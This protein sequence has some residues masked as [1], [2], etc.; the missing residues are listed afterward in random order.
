M[1]F[2][3]VTPDYCRSAHESNRHLDRGEESTM[4]GGFQM[5]PCIVITEEY[6]TSSTAIR[7][8]TG[9]NIPYWD[10]SLEICSYNEFLHQIR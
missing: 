9:Q 8:A 7:Y 5:V 2:H 10:A 3:F 4:S 6:G 1:A